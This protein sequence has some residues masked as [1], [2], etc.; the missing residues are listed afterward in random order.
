V[1][2]GPFDKLGDM[3]EQRIWE[4]AQEGDHGLIANHVRV[5]QAFVDLAHSYGLTV[6]VFTLLSPAFSPM[7]AL[8]VDGLVASDPTSLASMLPLA[9]PECS[10]GIDDDADGF[11]DFPQDPGCWGPEDQ[12]E[13][14]A[15]SDGLDNDLDG[16]TDFPQDPGCFSSFY[17]WEATAC[18]NGIDDNGDG[19]ADFP[20]DP[21]CF[22]SFDQHEGLTCS[23]GLDN[24]ADGFVDFPADP[25][26]LSREDASEN[27][28]DLRCDDGIDNDLDGRMDFPE[29]PGCSSPASAPENPP[30]NDG[31]DNDFDGQIDLA[32]PNCTHAWSSQEGTSACGL[33][34]E[35]ALV[36]APLAA[37]DRRRRR[38]RT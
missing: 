37:F 36:L 8:G 6:F 33:G 1:L 15:C 24:D 29:D 28:P 13:S 9:D 35:L 5:N 4:R 30:C 3:Q 34:S 7:L 38:P 27:A 25:G 12:A 10:D 22:S 11:V 19:L 18:S 26:C 23:D 17:D 31:I 20:S 14:A 21:G 16:Y 32:D 2:F